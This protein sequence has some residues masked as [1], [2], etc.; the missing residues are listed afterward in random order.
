MDH[1]QHIPYLLVTLLVF[2]IVV[3]LIAQLIFNERSHRDNRP[4]PG[5]QAH[6]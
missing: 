5:V 4:M 6:M 1:S 3:S 2:V